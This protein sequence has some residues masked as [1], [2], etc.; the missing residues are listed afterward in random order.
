LRHFATSRKVAGSIPDV[1][2]EF[3]IDIILSAA[4]RPLG[5]TQP[6]T[7]MSTRKNS[8]GKGGRCVGLTTLPTLCAEYLEIWE[9]QTSGT[10]WACPGLQQDFFTFTSVLYFITEIVCVSRYLRMNIPSL[11]IPSNSLNNSFTFHIL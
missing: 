8:W 11:L 2:M 3:F 1:S 9:S 6:L 7:E 5:L 10:L 4:L